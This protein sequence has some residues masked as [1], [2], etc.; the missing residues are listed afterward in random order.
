MTYLEKRENKEKL[1]QKRKEYNKEYRLNNKE[2]IAE[3]AKEYYIYNKEQIKENTKKYQKKYYLENKKEKK[4]YDK[5]HKKEYYLKNKEK[6]KE[7]KENNKETLKEYCLKNK[8]KTKEYQKQY[9]L[10]NKQQ[11]S[12][13][14]KKYNKIN[15][16]HIN[17]QKNNKKQTDLLFKLTCNIRSLICHSI[18]RQGYAKKSRTYQIL[19]CTYEEFKQHLERQFTFGMNWENQGEWHLDHV[20]PVSLAK[21]EQ[22]LIKLNHYTN[23]QP[24]WAIDNLLKG[25]KVIANTQI[26]LV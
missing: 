13:K 20:Y 3:K 19:G 17:K 12:E 14:K 9:R 24:L 11:L 22:E 21:D 26:K 1:L 6:I 5:K 4:I 15:S 18:K 8:E 16:Q 23:F 10:D 2:K 7:W 25:N